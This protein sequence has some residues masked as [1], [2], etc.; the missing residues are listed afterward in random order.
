MKYHKNFVQLFK[1]LTLSVF[2]VLGIIFPITSHAS[3]DSGNKKIV[4]EFLSRIQKGFGDA[5]RFMEDKGILEKRLDLRGLPDGEALILDIIIPP[6]L[7]VEGIVF[8]EISN[9]A[10][11]VSFR[12]FISILQF[13]IDYDPETNVY[14]GWYLKEANSFRFDLGTDLI[15][16]KG[17]EYR[18]SDL[19]KVQED[20]IMVSLDDIEQWF[21][22]EIEVDISTQRLTLNPTDPFPATRRF[23]RRKKN[24]ARGFKKKPE[25][26]RYDSDGYDWIETPVADITTRS[27]Y[28][29]RDNGNSDFDHTINI[30][31]AGEFLKG[32]LSTNTSINDEDGLFSARI[33]YLQESADPE[34]LGSLGARRF[35]VGDLSP[36]RL[37]ITGSAAPET[38]VRIT[39][40]DP[41]VSFTLPSTRIEG[42][43]FPDWDIEL[44][45]ENSLLAFQ[46]TD[47]EGYYVFESVP[48]FSNRNFFRI[49]AYGPQGEVREETINIPYDRDRLA[50]SGGVYDISLTFQNRQFYRRDESSD[51]DLDTPHVVGFYEVPIFEKSALRVGGRY[52][53]E[54]GEDKFYASA[55][56]STSFQ[57]ALL[58]AEIATDDEG[59]LKSELSAVTQFGP[60]RARV[61]LDL[62]TDNYSPNTSDSS[63]NILS[64][65]YNVEGPLGLPFGLSP[66][67][68]ANF[69]YDIN[70]DNEVSKSGFFTVNTQLKGFG[71]NQSFNY[72]DS[73]TSSEDASYGGTTALTGFYNRHLFR[74]IAQY[75][76]EPESDLESLTALWRYQYNSALDSQLQV[77]HAFDEDDED[78]TSYSARLN[79][80]TDEAV[81][82]PSVSYNSEGDVEALLNTRFSIAK[83]PND[84]G[85][86]MTRDS[87]TTF[88]NLTALVFLD[89]NGDFAFNSGDE[90][91]QNAKIMAPQNSGGGFT[92]D[93][94]IAYITRFRPSLIT[95]IYLDNSSLQD[96]FWISATDG[97]SVMPRTGN[98]IYM[99]FPV[100]VSGEVDGSVYFR[101]L[102]GTVK[103]AR[104]IK[105]AL[106][107]MLGEL[108][109]E[110]TTGPDGFYLFS[111]IPPGRYY[112][113]IS[114][115]SIGSD[116]GRP[117]PQ[118]V[119][120]NHDGTILYEQDFY[121]EQGRPDVPIK[122]RAA[123][124]ESTE[125]QTL[126][127]NLGEYNST[128]M[129]AYQWR[130]LT[131]NFSYFLG[132]STRVSDET[133]H[134]LRVSLPESHIY[135]G[136]QRCSG[137]VQAGNFCEL[138]VYLAPGQKNP[139]SL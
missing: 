84:N 74:G 50:E 100:H 107:N 14:S 2:F 96:P 115:K 15:S 18:L 109:M 81:I 72:S 76:F 40:A 19:S 104:N 62:A 41:L 132:G 131:K 58:N 70:S 7:A 101:D 27:N 83:A 75:A 135:S 54:D 130:K 26:P 5:D 56:L 124:S 103:S 53:Q 49:V 4:D 32:N 20:D 139:G 95:D 127:L 138:E 52:R 21:Q 105:L 64:N 112:M 94:G 137:L 79:W 85:F 98:N 99:E 57:D 129:T 90:P 11:L 69:R 47:S 36:T 73:D 3:P 33:T 46:E 55:A 42:Y 89:K 82:T 28:T 44:Y 31:T 45:R 92:N 25:L 43:Y 88:G 35:E 10:V 39:N 30:R 106:Y 1:A 66:R 125:S 93:K 110:T 133:D 117:L 97:H 77:D 16:S 121:I 87:L 48:L 118:L 59:A 78:L 13:P 37:P 67:Y 17:Q 65:R 123:A 122:I 63:V 71:F 9:Q 6:R 24:Y 111:L 38:G 51:E 114:D 29:K 136:Y 86:I 22:M 34:L 120:F 113:M 80:R 12:D 102:D 61:D 116:Y 68:N 119:E 60:H 128:L 126:A 134:V 23:E 8:A 108:E 91:I